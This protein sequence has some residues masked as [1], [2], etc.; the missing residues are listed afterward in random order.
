M[1]AMQQNEF[2]V[3]KVLRGGIAKTQVTSASC[4]YESRAKSQSEPELGPI[5]LGHDGGHFLSKTEEIK[6][7]IR[8]DVHQLQSLSAP[9]HLGLEPQSG[10]GVQKPHTNDVSGRG[11]YEVIDSRELAAR[12]C[13]PE[14]WVRDYVRAR[15]DDPIPHVNF[16]KYVRFLWGSPDLEDWVARRIVKGNNRRVERVP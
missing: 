9:T 1:P 11:P 8:S 5:D 10:K 7:G 3:P 16:G 14:S 6:T 2:A 13:V 4:R 12:W 15:A